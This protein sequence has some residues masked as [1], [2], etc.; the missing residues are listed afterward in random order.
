VPTASD[1]RNLLGPD[2][3]DSVV[4]DGLKAAP[5]LNGCRG[6]ILKF[7]E[8]SGRFEVQLEGME[9]TKAFKASNL[10]LS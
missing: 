7:I 10:R 4:V 1:S 2:V 9:G 5:E 8:D 3:G 6:K